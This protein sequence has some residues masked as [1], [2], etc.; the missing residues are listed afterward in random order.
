MPDIRRTLSN[1]GLALVFALGVFVLVSVLP[2]PG[3]WRLLAVLSG[4]ME[5]TLHTGSLVVVKPADHYK[6]GDIITFQQAST[7]TST[8]GTITHRIVNTQK[9]N[10]TDVF[11]TKGD[12]NNAPDALPVSPGNIVGKERVTIPYLGYILEFLHNPI[13]LIVLVIIPST[14][15]I[16][17]ELRK[18]RQEVAKMKEAKAAQ[19]AAAS[20]EPEP[21]VTT[22]VTA[23][24]VKVAKP[25]AKKKKK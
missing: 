16:G 24:P 14:L 12:A 13:G 1:T 7:D 15:I 23:E 5:P 25:K 11:Q 3:A 10:G 17:E 8:N 18:I 4:S 6:V 9:V 21:E 2:I 22:P 19:K 20:T